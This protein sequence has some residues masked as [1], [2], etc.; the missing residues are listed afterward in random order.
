M[1]SQGRSKEGREKQGEIGR[2]NERE[3]GGE[4]SVPQYSF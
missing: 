2:V 4:A 1:A 3:S